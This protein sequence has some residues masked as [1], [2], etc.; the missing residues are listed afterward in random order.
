[1]ATIERVQRGGACAPGLGRPLAW[2]IPQ[3]LL[4]LEGKKGTWLWSR[5]LFRQLAYSKRANGAYFLAIGPAFYRIDVDPKQDSRFRDDLLKYFPRSPTALTAD[6]RNAFTIWP[7][8][9]YKMPLVRTRFAAKAIEELPGY[10]P[11]IWQDPATHIIASGFLP[12]PTPT[13]T[14]VPPMSP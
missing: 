8:N 2:P 9:T 12:P 10:D 1:L 3:E 4:L 11:A 5:A 13:I 6:D 7:E 14:S